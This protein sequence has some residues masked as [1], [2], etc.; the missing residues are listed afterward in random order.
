MFRAT[1]RPSSGVQNCKCRLWFYIRLWW[2]AA[3][4]NHKRIQNQ[5][6][7][8][9]PLS[10]WWWAACSSKHV[11]HLRN[12]GIINSTTRSHLVGYFYKIYI[13]IHGSMNIKYYYSFFPHSISVCRLSFVVFCYFIPIYMLIEK[14]VRSC[15][16]V[17]EKA[18]SRPAW[19]WRPWVQG[20]ISRLKE[21]ITFPQ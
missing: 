21:Y 6:L 4:N 15:G 2:P 5:R 18:Y 1:H 10:S 20:F 3:A 14:K 12:T 19:W 16:F 17:S 7:H 13:M 11:E 9:Q 8:L